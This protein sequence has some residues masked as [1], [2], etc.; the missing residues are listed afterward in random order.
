MKDEA[1][2]PRGLLAIEEARSKRFAGKL[3]AIPTR[4]WLWALTALA[5]WGVFYWKQ[6]Q[7]EVD[8]RKAALFAKQRGVVA[9][10][11][12]RFEPMR[13]RLEDWTVEA[14]GPYPGDVV[15]PQVKAWDFAGLPGIYL[16]IR[17]D[18]ATSVPALRKAATGSLRDAFTACLFHEPNA[19]PTSGPP[20]KASHDCAAGTFC[21]EVD[22]CTPP[23]QPYNL[24][25]AYHGTRVLGDEWSV[26]LRT[27]GD[28]MR[29][30]LLE[31]EFESA[32]KDDVPLVIDML[33]RA[34]FYLLVL[35]EDPPGFAPPAGK[36]ALEAIQ[37]EPHAA[38]VLLYGLK[39]GMDRLL[40]RV[41]RDVAGRFI[42]AG[43]NAATDPEIVEAQQRQVNSCQLALDVRAAIG[44]AGAAR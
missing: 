13:Q 22:H 26:N 39:Q 6:T 2:R 11:G 7:G 36:P 28:D 33:T 41:R 4:Y 43:E 12:P 10:L 23:A 37:A 40:L 15:S 34:Q 21:N 25:A 19:D 8:S 17:R 44:A 14:A 38:R 18:S 3:P 24:R 30:R 32:V 29:M 5:A 1:S 20:C 16:R 31:R 35:D 42:P 27:A 9:E